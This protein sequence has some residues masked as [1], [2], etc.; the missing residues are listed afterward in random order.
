[1]QS[2]T[3][4]AV[5]EEK[6]CV[7]VCV[8]MDGKKRARE[9]AG[10]RFLSLSTV[11]DLLQHSTIPFL[12][13]PPSASYLSVRSDLQSLSLPHSFLLISLSL[14]L[15]LSRSVSLSLPSEDAIPEFDEPAK[16]SFRPVASEGDPT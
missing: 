5:K 3:T 2:V 6:V 10:E 4:A 14:S 13:S 9:R 16:L 7:C 15:T 12:S 11:C 1:M 8:G